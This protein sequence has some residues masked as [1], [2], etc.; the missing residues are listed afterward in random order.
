MCNRIKITEIKQFKPCQCLTLDVEYASN[1]LEILLVCYSR[2][3][4]AVYLNQCPHTGVNLNWQPDQCFDVS[5][6]YLACSLHGAL[7]QPVDGLCVYGPCLGQSLK[8][9]AIEIED[10][11]LYILP[12]SIDMR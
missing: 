8:K 9:V 10:G 5:E 12:D 1:R 4:F 7:F 3:K 11:V 2:D 6:Q